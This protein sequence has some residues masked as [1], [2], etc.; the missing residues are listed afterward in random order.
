VTVLDALGGVSLG[1]V[2]ASTDEIMGG[3]ARQD[4]VISSAGAISLLVEPAGIEPATPSLSFVW[5]RSYRGAGA[6]RRDVSDRQALP[7]PARY[8]MGMARRPA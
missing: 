6:G 8:G 1:G 5:S 2:L 3:E 4:A 7:E